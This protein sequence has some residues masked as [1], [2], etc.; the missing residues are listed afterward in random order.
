MPLTKTL[1]THPDPEC[2]G[3]L[4]RLVD[5]LCEWERMTGQQS[6]LLLIPHRGGQIMAYVNGRPQLADFDEFIPVLRNA[7]R[8]RAEAILRIGYPDPVRE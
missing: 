8:E 5:C 3:A 7:I 6:T 2:Q 1:P 4:T